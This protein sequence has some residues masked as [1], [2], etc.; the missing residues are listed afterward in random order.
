MKPWSHVVK[1][2]MDN[3]FERVMDWSLQVALASANHP[4]NCGRRWPPA[5]YAEERLKWHLDHRPTPP[6]LQ[7]ALAN[8]IDFDF[9]DIE[10][11][12]EDAERFLDRLERGVFRLPFE[13][14][15]VLNRQTEPDERGNVTMEAGGPVPTYRI[16]HQAKDANVITCFVFADHYDD[17][18]TSICWFPVGIVTLQQPSDGMLM[19]VEL[20]ISEQRALKMYGNID[21]HQQIA[22]SMRG[23]LVSIA[24][25]ERSSLDKIPGPPPT[26]LNKARAKK[27]LPTIRPRYG[28]KI[29]LGA[30][31][32]G[33]PW[34]GGTHA[35]PRPHMRRGHVRHLPSGA[36]TW[37]REARVGLD[38]AW[39]CDRTIYSVVEK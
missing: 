2:T 27:G 11:H 39:S 19:Q 3:A 8:A 18:G 10:M 23:A 14:V 6:A 7:L 25:L 17:A 36:T 38:D 12:E 29:K 15:A 30:K 28:V 16:L 24:S 34:L 4:P 22:R 20:L 26:K 5:V 9:S 31:H 13:H 1:E 21:M 33:T 37:V 35:S 32:E